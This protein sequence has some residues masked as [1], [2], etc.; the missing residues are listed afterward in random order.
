MHIEPAWTRDGKNL[1]FV[2]NRDVPLGSGNVW[3]IPV[4][5]DAMQ[6]AKPV[7]VGAVAV[8]PEARRLD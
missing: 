1:L 3:K 4:E 7:L 8:P 5:P 6:K 2:S